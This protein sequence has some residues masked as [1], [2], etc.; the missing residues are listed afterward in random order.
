MSRGYSIAL[1][2][3]IILSTTAIFIR[4]LTE[5]YAIP[6]LVLA[7]WRDV[8]VAGG[9]LLVLVLRFLHLL[10]VTRPHLGYLAVYGLVLATFNASW[11]FSVAMTGAAV[12]TVLVYT[13]ATFTAV[14]GWWLFNERLDAVKISAI[15]LTLGGCVLVSGAL[16]AQTVD[17]GGV[18]LG[19]LSGLCYAFYSLMGRSASQRGLNTWTTM[20]HTFTFAALFLGILVSN[21]NAPDIFWLGD[22]AEGWS[23]LVLL[24]VGPT[25]AGFGTYTLSLSYLPSSIANLVATTEPVF[26]AII[27]YFLLNERLTGV[28]VSGSILLLFGVAL[29][30]LW[31]IYARTR[32]ARAAAAPG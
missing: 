17:A 6:P 28:Q 26:T 29:L 1:L 9:L 14:F 16:D 30:R 23:I 21:T 11:T 10:L 27:A 13:S 32:R 15:G 7:F 20:L 18:A 24:A 25:L 12:A 4:H 31:P 22:S 3:A 8:F 2:S 19:I 5:V